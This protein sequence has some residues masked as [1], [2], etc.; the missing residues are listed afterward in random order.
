MLEEELP[1]VRG[2]GEGKSGEHA[3]F[4]PSRVGSFSGCCPSPKL[5]LLYTDRPTLESREATQ[6]RRNL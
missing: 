2:R 4:S 1:Q 5:P 3:A 6:A